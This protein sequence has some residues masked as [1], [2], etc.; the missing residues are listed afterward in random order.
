M[1][2]ERP[3]SDPADEPKPDA[4]SFTSSWPEPPAA[5]PPS[6][7]TP[8]PAPPFSAPP[9]TPPPPGAGGVG[10]PTGQAGPPPFGAPPFGAPPGPPP[11]G[12]PPGTEQPPP[13]TAFAWRH[14]LVRPTKGRLLAG[15]CA[16]FGRATNTDPILW[17]VVLAVLALFGIGI[18]AYLVGWLFVPAE[19][20]TATPVEALVGRGR[21]STSAILTVIGGVIMLISAGVALSEPFRP[22]LLGAILLGGAVLLLLRDQ[23]G[24]VR[25]AGAAPVA[26]PMWSTTTGPAAGAATPPGVPPVGTPEPMTPA[27]PRTS[28]PFAPYGPFAP[29]P[30]PAAAYPGGLPPQPPVPSPPVFPP[31]PPAPKPRRPRSRLGLLILSVGL[32][33]VGALAIVDLAGFHIPPG[34]YAAAA[35]ATVGF[36]LILGAWYGRARWMIALG[37]ILSISVA[38]SVGVDK[39]GEQRWFEGFPVQWTPISAD[40]LQNSYSHDFGDATLDLSLVDFAEKP[41]GV[42][43]VDVKVDWGDL[44]IIA[45]PNVD[46]YVNAHVDVGRADVLGRTWAGLDAGT[47]SIVDY[48]A[49]GQG[50]GEL[51]IDARTDVGKLEVRR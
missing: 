23:R 22:G 20:D 12:P 1:T 7:P 34:G 47:Q 6:A 43:Y 45:P 25:A 50:G 33:V 13:I 38:L 18:I 44:S 49:D 35:L 39:M 24:K 14:G 27:E 28:P 26:A 3:T 42:Y 8:P 30:P 46:L 37:V 2:D 48:G 15:V 10:P 40:E 9:P 29:G 4:P 11:Y 41:G 51:H 19:G 5:E 31:R 32:I 16:G 17:R 21:S 36:G